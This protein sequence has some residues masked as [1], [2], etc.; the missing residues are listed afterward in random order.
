MVLL[1]NP[2]DI[3]YSRD[4]RLYH[5]VNK[6]TGW[7]AFGSSPYMDSV[8]LHFMEDD[9]NN[10]RTIE[11]S[12]YQLFYRYPPFE[13]IVYPPT[14]YKPRTSDTSEEQGSVFLGDRLW[15]I[16]VIQMKNKNKEWLAKRCKRLKSLVLRD[17][18]ASDQPKYCVVG[19]LYGSRIKLT[20]VIVP[21][22]IGD[23]NGSITMFFESARRGRRRTYNI[24]YGFLRN[25]IDKIKSMARDLGC[26]EK[27]FSDIVR[28][29]WPKI[30]D[31]INRKYRPRYNINI[32]NYITYCFNGRY[33]TTDPICT[34][35]RD[36][37]ICPA[38]RKKQYVFLCKDY[39]GL[40]IFHYSKKVFPRVYANM[41]PS[42]IYRY[43]EN[44]SPVSVEI[45]DKIRAI[46]EVESF[47]I[48]LPRNEILELEPKYKPF[49][50]LTRTRGL[51]I[52]VGK[53]FVKALISFIRDTDMDLLKIL[54]TKYIILK[55]SVFGVTPSVEKNKDGFLKHNDKAVRF[56]AGDVDLV[57]A[58]NDLLVNG[59]YD[60]QFIEYIGKTLMHTLSHLLILEISHQLELELEKLR[61]IYG[62][63]NTDNDTLF[64]SAI[65]E[66]SKYGTLM[67]E[68]S[69][70]EYLEKLGDGDLYK[71]FYKLLQKICEYLVELDK[72]YYTNY[73]SLKTSKTLNV[74]DN[75]I[76]LILKLVQELRSY[77]EQNN[78]ITDF[79]SFKQIVSS[80][81]NINQSDLI[82]HIISYMRD[83]YGLKLSEDDYGRIGDI[84][85]QELENIIGVYGPDYCLDGC[86]MDILLGKDCNMP[87]TEHLETS[88][89][90]FYAFAKLIGVAT[91][92]H[93]SKVTGLT[94][95]RLT[96]TARRKLEIATSHTND[97]ALDA[98]VKLLERG[99]KIEFL[100]DMRMFRQVKDKLESLRRKYRDRFKYGV[101]S[102][103]FHYKLYRIDDT[104]EIHTSWNFSTA[105]NVI[106]SM[107][108]NN[109]LLTK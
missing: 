4:T 65:V 108:I 49:T 78:V 67:V 93:V 16:D 71:G 27:Y 73:A 7:D 36:L 17:A 5:V 109:L 69:I 84:V 2:L 46:T 66:N 80:L 34:Y 57:E 85:E 52:H 77:L 83:K 15:F 35:V 30:S 24:A 79:T 38:C 97:Q 94:V 90:L 88:K 103:P 18:Q 21:R 20:D 56:W 64:Y 23:F 98:L 58:V 25:T 1:V 86:N 81:L 96:M 43:G 105:S 99:V 100:I 28:N 19:D 13:P 59:I 60:N 76:Q 48:Y 3:I 45:S 50:D 29:C 22:I 6:I 14:I 31:I 62:V 32:M 106:Q 10:T 51:V 54:A 63:Q 11:V 33:V 26:R 89:R 8:L 92:N 102:R 68:K 39:P 87:L 61:Y 91:D 70:R 82:T 107:E 9:L 72:N 55:N 53:D 74:K 12:F 41:R 44:R 47:T 104:I 101:S 75:L 37:R 40:G 42:I 95:Y